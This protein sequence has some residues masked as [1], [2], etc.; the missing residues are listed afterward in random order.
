M[1]CTFARGALTR[2]AL[3][4]R[5]R[6]PA[7]NDHEYLFSNPVNAAR[8][9]QAIEDSVAGRNMI[10]MTLEEIERW[11]EVRMAAAA[12]GVDP[13]HDREACGLTLPP[14]SPKSSADSGT[15]ESAT[16]RRCTI[17]PASAS[18][19]IRPY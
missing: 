18:D 15:V 4:L 17:L 13:H 12:P 16:N 11:M 8:L 7:R 1:S 6:T 14:N 2:L 19:P 9:R 5:R 3:P 10:R